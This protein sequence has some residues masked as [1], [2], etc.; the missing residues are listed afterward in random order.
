MRAA[1][2]ASKKKKTIER[3]GLAIL[4]MGIGSKLTETL[5]GTIRDIR[6]QARAAGAVRLAAEIRATGALALADRVGTSA[7]TLADAAHAQTSAASLA[8]AWRQRTLHDSLRALRKE[9]DVVA[10]LNASAEALDGSVRRTA[11]TENAQAFNDG[12]LDAS[13]ELV[14]V[15]DTPEGVSLLDADLEGM[16]LVDKWDAVLDSRTCQECAALD[17][18]MTPMG[19]I[20]T[21]GE[22]PGYIHPWCRC[23]RTTMAVPRQ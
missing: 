16:I 3:A 10:V 22:E 9:Q 11:A 5:T 21:S 7:T 20:F 6:E 8:N 18:D 17:G 13:E 4:L 14:G 2:A 1:A 15:L 19:A 23:I 12:H